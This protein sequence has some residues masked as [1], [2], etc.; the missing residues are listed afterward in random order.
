[1]EPVCDYC[2]ITDKQR[3]R[4]SEQ[5]EKC[6]DFNKKV[7]GDDATSHPIQWNL[8]LDDERF[9]P[10]DGKQWQIART[11]DDALMLLHAF[12]CP[13]FISFDHDLG[14][15]QPTGMDFA[16]TLVYLDQ[17]TSNYIPRD[18]TFYVHSQNPVGAANIRSY[19]TNYLR[20]R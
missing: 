12:G 4:T 5:A 1:M 6:A 13:T 14:E 20:V 10:E 7:P 8:F 11:V 9:P 2:G 18:F 17:K 3:C 15:D 19:L 16:K